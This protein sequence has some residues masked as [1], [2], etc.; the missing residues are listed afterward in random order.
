M[1]QIIKALL[2]KENINISELERKIDLKRNT[3]RSV[4]QRNYKIS[5]EFLCK[6]LKGFPEL[7]P[8]WLVTEEGEMYRR[9][10]QRIEDNLSSV[11]S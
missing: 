3:I 7:N 10:M 5:Q 4:M 2:D 11:L 6:C 8:E 9:Q 1:S